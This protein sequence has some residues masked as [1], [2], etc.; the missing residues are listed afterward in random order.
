MTEEIRKYT[1]D[2]DF[3]KFLEVQQSRLFFFFIY[4]IYYI[5]YILYIYIL[6][7]FIYLFINFIEFI[8]INEL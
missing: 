6:Y 2:Q 1:L 4:I 3:N 7:I 8:L 5:Y